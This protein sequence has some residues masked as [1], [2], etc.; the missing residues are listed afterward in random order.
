MATKTVTTTSASATLGG[1]AFTASV[2]SLNSKFTSN[3]L[4]RSEHFVDLANLLIQAAG[5]QHDWTDEYGR[6]TAGNYNTEGYSPRGSTETR[7]VDAIDTNFGLLSGVSAE[8]V[9]DRTHY[10]YMVTV[11]NG[12]RT[13]KHSSEDA[14]S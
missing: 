10:N 14:T 5:H 7:T 2:N 8:E 4:I 12:L 1:S 11:Y 3:T 13:H 6:H 9:I